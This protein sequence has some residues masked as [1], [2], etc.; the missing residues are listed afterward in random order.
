MSRDWSGKNNPFWGVDRSGKLNPNWRGGEVTKKC[1]RCAK[2]VQ[3][4]K[5]KIKLY[6]THF[7]SN[8]CRIEN[9]K[10][11]AKT[12]WVIKKCDICKQKMK[13]LKT[14]TKKTCSRI[15]FLKLA[16]LLKNSIKNPM[17]KG[18][19]VGY[20]ALHEWIKSRFH[21]PV[22]CQDCKKVP[23]YDLANISQKYKRD[24]SDWEWL[25]RKCHMTKDGRIG[26]LKHEKTLKPKECLTCQTL[27]QPRS[28]K[29]KCCS[30]ECSK[31]LLSSLLK[32]SWNKKIGLTRNKEI[33]ELRKQGLTLQKI[34]TQFNLSIASISLI[35]SY[36][37]KEQHFD[38]EAV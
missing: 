12:K 38:T 1:F 2:E 14:R 20:E 33:T 32:Q 37:L 17:W 4:S 29:T 3:K 35:C 26:N 10:E 30:R 5:S 22:V 25:C 7:C 15:C 13:T 36:Y 34:A 8:K 16:S 21:K 28:H 19:K 31:K 6:L 11:I 18:E 24:I 27:F 23:P 9:W